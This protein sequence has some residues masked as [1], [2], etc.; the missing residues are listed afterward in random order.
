MAKLQCRCGFIMSSSMGTPDF[1]V[2]I[3]KENKI[4]DIAEIIESNSGKIDID[5]FYNLIDED[6]IFALKCPSC[7]RIYIDI[8][9]GVFRSYRPEVL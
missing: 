3:I 2:A 1:E 4:E 6:A 9:N 5:T 8:G 7:D